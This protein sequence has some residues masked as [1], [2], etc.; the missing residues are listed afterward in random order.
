[1]SRQAKSPA[2]SSISGEV[3]MR[4]AIVAVVM[5]LAAVPVFGGQS[6]PNPQLNARFGALRPSQSADP[7]RNLFRA[8][9][10]LKKAEAERAQASP[11][12]V[13]GM[14]IIPA[15]PKIDPKMAITPK[16]DGLDFKMRAIEPPI[17]NPAR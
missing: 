7:Y 10:L 15:D 16:K 11:K 1:M 17:C 4:N 14:T 2:R 13:C 9:E 6:T 8:Q 12:V 5:L 3:P